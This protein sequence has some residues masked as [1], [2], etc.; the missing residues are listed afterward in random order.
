MFLLNY[1]NKLIVEKIPS[2]SDIT[3]VVRSL[4]EDDSGEYLDARRNVMK[5]INVL[6]H[7][8][9]TVVSFKC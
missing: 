9:T 2:R 7:E 3:Q 8:E 6:G 4:M 5:N 1:D